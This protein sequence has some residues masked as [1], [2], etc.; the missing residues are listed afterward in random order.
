MR[1]SNQSTRQTHTDAAVKQINTQIY[2]MK[3]VIKQSGAALVVALVLLL[4]MTIL[5][6][7]VVDSSNLQGNMSRNSQFRVHSYQVALSEISAQLQDIE[8]NIAA[9]DDA[10][11]NGTV[12]R[13]GGDIFMQPANFAQTVRIDYIGEGMPPPGYSVD[14]YVGRIFEIDSRAQVN[15]TGIFSDQTQGLNYAGP[16]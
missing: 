4:V 1:L 11:V 7:A 10:L 12:N 2:G 5:G 6:V 8:N 13:V 3:Q 16:K 14:T 15:N 9:L